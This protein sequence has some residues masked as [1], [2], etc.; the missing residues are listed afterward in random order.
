MF[1]FPKHPLLVLA[2]TLSLALCAL[3]VGAQTPYVGIGRTAT[4]KELVAWDIDVRPD[5]K[6]LPKGSG[7]VAA[8]QI[9]WEAQCASCH[10]VFGEANEV[11]SPLVGG[12]SKDD[13]KTGR[14]ARLL[15]NSFPGRTTLMKVATVST[16]FD[17]IQR[18]MPWNAPKSLKPDEVYAVLA[19]M[20]NLADVVDD[21]FTLND[22]NIAQVQQ[23][24]PNRNGM[25]LDHALWPGST[26]TPRGAKPDTRATACMSR[27]ATEAK[28]ASLLPDY[29]RGSHGDLAE[30]VRPVGA[31][32]SAETRATGAAAS[33]S[34]PA[35]ASPGWA[36]AQRHSCNACHGLENKVV[37]PGLREVAAKY[38][39][40]ADAAAYLATRIK[41]GS[42][43]IWGAIPMP[44]QSLPDNETQALAQ[45]LA[46][47]APK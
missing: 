15:D 14:V 42:S 20:L 5:F 36:L 24:M 4:Q 22:T 16:L 1:S 8:G 10:G 19:Y 12:T 25:R 11:F 3:G 21:K 23:R 31:V 46:Q 33:T 27:C 39:G 35:V 38:A 13:V 17:Y 44:P 26:I 41:A 7:S 6:G 32:K 30:Q 47:G 28:V 40:K 45:W 9:V 29:A 43:G 18:A 34:P 2:L 37:G